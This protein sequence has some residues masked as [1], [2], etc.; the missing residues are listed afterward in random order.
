VEGL[1][2]VQAILASIKFFR[3]N[4][5]DVLIL[6]LVVAAIS[7]GLQMIPG[8]F[9][10]EKGGYQLLSIITGLVDILVLAP[11]SNLWWT[12]LYMDRKGIH[13][14]EEVLDTW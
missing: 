11:L 10:P 2:P 14:F 12:M 9:N 4:R 8:L 7:L 6:W 3:Y 1:G 13:M 5:F